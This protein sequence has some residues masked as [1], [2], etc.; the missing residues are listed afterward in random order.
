MG[1]FAKKPEDAPKKLS[2]K[3]S[4]IARIVNLPVAGEWDRE[5]T[6]EVSKEILHPHQWATGFRLFPMQAEAVN[7]FKHLGG[8]FFPAPVGT[9]K[10]GVSL[11]CASL[12]HVQGVK[13]I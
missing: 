3:Q 1:L 5:K 10:T 2:P 4:E 7:D 11:I 6:E 12:A 8:G 13:K 9:G